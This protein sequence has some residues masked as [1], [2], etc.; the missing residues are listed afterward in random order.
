MSTNCVFIQKHKYN[1]NKQILPIL[2]KYITS[3]PGQYD[4]KVIILQFYLQVM[5]FKL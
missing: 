4:P 2:H 1:L 3:L 5:C